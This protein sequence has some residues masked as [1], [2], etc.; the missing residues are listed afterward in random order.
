MQNGFAELFCAYPVGQDLHWAA[1]ESS[2]YDPRAHDAHS[3]WPDRCWYLPGKQGS[4]KECPSVL[5]WTYPWGQFMHDVLLGESWKVP[6]AQ[7]AH[8]VA[9]AYWDSF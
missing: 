1:Y 2:W 3:P 5:F 7:A 9:W 4:Q 8:D 6:L